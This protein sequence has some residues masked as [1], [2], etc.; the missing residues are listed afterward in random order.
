MLDSTETTKPP[1]LLI[2][3]VGSSF[4]HNWVEP[5]WVELLTESGRE[6]VG[7]ELP[8]HG[9]AAAV[10][11]PET[12]AAERIIDAAAAAG[13]VDAV[14]FSAGGYALIAAVAARPELFRKT[15]LMGISDQ[16]LTADR[17]GRDRVAEL[18]TTDE[19]DLN[20][21]MAVVIHRLI[22]TAGNEPKLV[23]R[24][25]ASE[26]PR[27]TWAAV[28][29]ITA[30]TLVVEGSEDASGT[31]EQLASTIPGAQHVVLKGVDHFAIPSD[32]HGMHSVLSFLDDPAPADA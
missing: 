5:G 32:F 13:V 22:R 30:H 3:G 18:F 9:K 12:N 29:G 8:G 21:P 26:Q 11:E 24:F 28:A 19:V 10:I 17:Q 27:P 4:Q 23:A 7:V 20:N 6:V 25:M 14:G 16:G 31:A 1:V 15:A 2:H